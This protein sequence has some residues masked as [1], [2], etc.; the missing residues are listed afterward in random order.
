MTMLGD[1][2]RRVC[3]VLVIGSGAAGC[4]A[5]I[6]AAE[7]GARVILTSKGVFGK[8]GTTNLACVVY[9][10]A[11]GHADP[12]DSPR[13]QFE[14][15]V[16]YGRFLNNQD[17]AKRF[18]D[19]AIKSVYDLE[20]YGMEWWK[21]EDGRFL[22]LTSPGLRY[23]R[24]LHNN[25]ETGKK[26]QQALVR[27]IRRSTRRTIEVS[28][29]LF[30]TDLVRADGRVIGAIGIDYKS[31]ALV[32]I[33][34]RNVIL[35]TGGLGMMYSV[36]DMEAGATGEGIA[37]AYRA[38]AE[39][40]DMEMHQFFPTAFVHPESL[41]GIIVTSSALWVL[42]LKLYNAAGERF[43]EKYYPEEQ[44]NVPRDILSRHI[45]L[46]IAEGRGTEHGG[47]WIDT[48]DI[49]NF[50]AIRKERP[51]TYLWK[52]RFGV[53]TDRFEV[54]PTY[55]YTLGGIRIDVDGRTTVAGLY[56]AGECTGGVHG[57]N[58]LAGNALPDCMA[59]GRVAGRHAALHPGPQV[60]I[61]D[62]ELARA[63]QRILALV[64][65]AVPVVRVNRRL[66]ELMY[67]HVGII[68]SGEGLA[69]AREA[70]R[71][72]RHQ[73]AE[74]RTPPAASPTFGLLRALETEAMVELAEVIVESALLRTE[75][76]GAH[77]RTDYPAA[78]NANWL[79]N[80]VARRTPEGPSLT[81]VPVDLK[82][83]RPEV[84]AI[85]AQSARL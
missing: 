77:Y 36:T 17:L 6:E 35:A 46:E 41:R 37:M 62:Q 22:Q 79:R 33:E 68:R 43:M 42:G 49:P 14:D 84:V 82:Y 40:I 70:I 63:R 4:R 7:Y 5:A 75:S 21:T 19:E 23:P 45:F 50:D 58:R 60:P 72:L 9:D 71:A 39:L 83:L 29:D 2:Q 18:A 31:G 59:F 20:R 78:D 26:M 11:V 67:R 55:H 12:R 57:A 53:K 69:A 56:A 65:D 47:V 15:T 44:E 16:I 85:E 10:A 76:R 81:T 52:D 25:E 28:E 32:A 34:A 3:D 54:A 30:I 66:R 1:T 73:A 51:R 80:I 74:M 38:G 13:V 27:E 61:D 24:G 64:G 48:R 8:S